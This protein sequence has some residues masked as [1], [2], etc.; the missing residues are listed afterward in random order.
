MNIDQVILKGF[1]NFN[2]A[3]IKFAQNTL[4]IGGNDVG[5]SNLMHA[6]RMLLDKSL[7]DMDIEPTELDF[8][9][10]KDG[11]QADTFEITIAFSKV[12]EDAVLSVLK[13]HVSDEGETFFRYVGQR[14]G[15]SFKLYMGHSLADLEE[16]DSRFYLKH[17]NLKYVHSQRDLQKFIQREKRHLLKFAQESL[18][19]EEKAHDTD[20]LAAITRSLGVINADVSQLKYVANA[21]RQVNDE[22]KELAHHHADYRVQLDSG[23]IQVNQFI[24]KLELG[25]NTNGSQ[26]ML[27]G[28]GRNNQI[29]LALWKSKSEREHDHNSQVTFYVVEEPEAHLH[30][31]QQRKLAQYLNTSLPGQSIITS[32]SPQ[33]TAKYS[34]DSI[35][36]LLN[37]D[38]ATRAASEGCSD[39]ISTAWDNMGYRM[40]ILPAEA[41]FASAVLL[42]E[43][44]SEVLFYSTLAEKLDIDL[45]FYNIS[46]LAVD[47]V[48]FEVYTKILNAM[49][50]PWAM[51]TDNDVSKITVE[52][53]PRQ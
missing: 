36:R 32:H 39:C 21:T 14:N 29:L 8:H 42:V 23:A 40:S 24:E 46:I 2:D 15:S 41:F 45:D 27:G 26:V 4:V 43:G 37:E 6:L 20:K 52:K 7:S 25:A 5:K 50:I 3:T 22:L 12:E 1:R 28:D 11:N 31:H 44:P 9:I 38:G 17:I 33:I 30:P 13:G 49:G 18:S 48:Q 19:D 34:P 53:V 35:I 16:I 51:R 47:G 10:D